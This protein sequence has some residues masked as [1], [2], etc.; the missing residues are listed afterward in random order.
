MRRIIVTLSALAIAASC[1]TPSHAQ[2]ATP[3]I[4]TPI[5]TTVT[6]TATLTPAQKQQKQMGGIYMT[7]AIVKATQVML[8]E[9]ATARTKN[10]N[11]MS[12]VAGVLAIAGVVSETKSI[13]AQPAALPEFSKHWADL[14]AHNNALIDLTRRWAIDKTIVAKDVLAELPAISKRIDATN[15]AIHALIVKRAG[16]GTAAD[17]QRDYDAQIATF[18]T[19]IQALLK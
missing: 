16:R 18:R 17:L 9:T 10:G 13:L 4:T 8:E 7:G 3:P 2:N 1:I 12:I 6:V 14:K 19:Q 15:A 11:S 5:T